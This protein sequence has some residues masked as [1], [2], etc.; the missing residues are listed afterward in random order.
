MATIPPVYRTF[1]TISKNEYE[2]YNLGT[3]KGQT[4]IKFFFGLAA[5]VCFFIVMVHGW[6]YLSLGAVLGILYF[7]WLRNYSKLIAQR[8]SQ[9][10]DRVIEA[11]EPELG[12][13]L[14]DSYLVMFFQSNTVRIEGHNL[15]LKPSEEHPDLLEMKI[16]DVIEKWR[17]PLG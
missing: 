10:F 4:K 9:F 1:F 7:R 12:Y 8:N 15:I 3:L 16:C 13:R 6:W 2:A 11:L 5:A 17:I 14:P